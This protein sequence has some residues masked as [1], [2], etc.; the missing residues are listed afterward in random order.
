MTGNI[1]SLT[2]EE[3]EQIA[4]KDDFHI[5]PFRE[6]GETYGT[7]TWIW[8]V[9]VDN[10]LYVRAY[11]G[12]NSRWYQS[13]IKQKAGK[14]EAAGMVKE[15]QFEPVTGNINEKID[16]AY[17]EKYSN[18]PYLQSMISKRAKAATVRVYKEDNRNE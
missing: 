18:S 12:V 13:A 8:V 1:T 5:A 2:I 9:M 15:V 10:Q 17:R 6:D 14:I 4:Q 7:P 16:D 3:I 11:N